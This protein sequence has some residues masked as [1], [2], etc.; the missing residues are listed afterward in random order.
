[1]NN[2]IT[3]HKNWKY[4]NTVLLILSLILLYLFADTQVVRG[5]IGEIGNLGYFGIFISGLFF[6][7]TFTVAPASVVLYTL[8]NQFNTLAI[9]LV[10]GLG[11]SIGDILILKFLKDKVFQE[12]HPLFIKIVGKRV[13][14]LFKTP[15]FA[16]L[17]P[18]IGILIIASPFPD[19]IG[20]GLL[21]VSKL[22]SW[23]FFLISFACNML[24]IFVIISL[25]K[26]L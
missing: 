9:A 6:V 19:E 1:M 5:L 12:L 20:I 22:N 11:A 25:A 14:Q 24:G 13:F 7:S 18:V 2:H 23:Q 21:G 8:S 15:Y 4:K 10:A 17:S 16:W 3:N 26:A